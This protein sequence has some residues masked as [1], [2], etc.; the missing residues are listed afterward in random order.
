MSVDKELLHLLLIQNA[1]IGMPLRDLAFAV[2]QRETDVEVTLIHEASLGHIREEEQRY[3][4]LKKHFPKNI[5]LRI[6]REPLILLHQLLQENQQGMLLSELQEKIPGPAEVI[7]E[8]LFAEKTVERVAYI[9]SES[10]S[11]ISKLEFPVENLVRNGRQ[12]Q[13]FQKTNRIP[14]VGVLAGLV[15]A[16]YYLIM[17]G[18]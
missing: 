6:E 11:Y 1:E 18:M 3:F 9:S 5:E 8:I 17:F 7:R 13:L 10:H 12:I 16:L 14:I 2:G 4:T 15:G